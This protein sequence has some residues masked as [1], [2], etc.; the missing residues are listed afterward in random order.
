MLFYPK[1]LSLFILLVFYYE[2][3]NW[4]DFSI[5]RAK[6]ELCARPCRRAGFCL[7]SLLQKIFKKFVTKEIRVVFS[8]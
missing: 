8:I 2:L 1:L 6:R 4:Q 7:L 3:R 5:K